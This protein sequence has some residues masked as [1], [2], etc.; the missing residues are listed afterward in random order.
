MSRQYPEISQDRYE[1]L[2]AALAASV[3]QM[4]AEGEE[5]PSTLKAAQ[6][7]LD[8]EVVKDNTGGAGVGPD[9]WLCQ[10]EDGYAVLWEAEGNKDGELGSM[11]GFGGQLDDWDDDWKGDI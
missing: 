7:A 3:A 10:F 11:N 5:W 4:H 8:F 6:R 9:G 1:S 2:N